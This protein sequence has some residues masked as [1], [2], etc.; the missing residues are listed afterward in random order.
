MF[1]EYSTLSSLGRVKVLS[2]HPT[3]EQALENARSRPQSRRLA[4]GLDRQAERWRVVSRKWLQKPSGPTTIFA[5]AIAVGSAVL[6]YFGLTDIAQQLNVL[7]VVGATHYLR[8]TTEMPEA[9]LRDLHFADGEEP[10]S[11]SEYGLDEGDALGLN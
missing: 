6:C 2:S 8:D 4:V 5:L 3:R 1:R 9:L 11:F 10:P 7:F